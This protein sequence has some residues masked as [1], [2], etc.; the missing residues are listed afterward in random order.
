MENF[1]FFLTLPTNRSSTI[2]GRSRTAATS[3]ME[4]FVIILFLFIFI[5]SLF[6]VDEFTIKRD[7]I[8]ML[9]KIAMF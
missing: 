7:I 3:K 8:L 5:Y 4:Q 9:I 1:I 2:R 6:E